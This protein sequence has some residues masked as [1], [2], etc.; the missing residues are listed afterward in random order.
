MNLVGGKKI[1]D[2]SNLA[3]KSLDEVVELIDDLVKVLEAA[4][5]AIPIP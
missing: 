3:G 4:R 5:K 2:F 1:P